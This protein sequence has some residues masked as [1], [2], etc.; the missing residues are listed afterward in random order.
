MLW[1]NWYRCTHLSNKKRSCR[2]DTARRSM[3]CKNEIKIVS[4]NVIGNSTDE[5]VGYKFLLQFYTN[6][7]SYLVAYSLWDITAHSYDIATFRHSSPISSVWNARLSHTF[8]A[9]SLSRIHEAVVEISIVTFVTLVRRRCCIVLFFTCCKQCVSVY[10][11]LSN[12]SS[13]TR[14][15]WRVCWYSL[16]A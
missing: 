13:S 3:S 6:F 4:L 16:R 15:M 2:R 11:S 1:E 10:C 14:C 12:L 5:Y 8:F 9:V 7:D